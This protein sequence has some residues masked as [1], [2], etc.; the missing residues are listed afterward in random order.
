[1]P[2]CVFVH[3]CNAIVVFWADD[4][5]CTV[6]RV[7]HCGHPLPLTTDLLIDMK[8]YMY[9]VHFCD[10]IVVVLLPVGVRKLVTW[11]V[12]V[13]FCSSKHQLNQNVV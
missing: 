5:T 2:R 9:L 13:S 3:Y 7:N 8:G 12:P 11:R 1:M 10:I 4:I 6:L